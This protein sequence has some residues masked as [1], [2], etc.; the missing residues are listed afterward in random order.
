MR[1]HLDLP[2]LRALQDEWRQHP[3]V[4]HLVAAY[5]GHKPPVQAG[6]PEHDE[7]LRQMLALMPATG[8]VAPLD[9]RAWD[10]FT[11]A[12]PAAPH[13]TKDPHD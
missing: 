9:T 5:L 2:A 4:H 13:S 1:N 12:Q 8:R 11:T 3:P 10:E 7:G 6:T